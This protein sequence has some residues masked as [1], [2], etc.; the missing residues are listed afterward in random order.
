MTLPKLN[1]NTGVRDPVSLAG[2]KNMVPVIT[3]SPDGTETYTWKKQWPS[4]Y[5]TETVSGRGNLF[6]IKFSFCMGF[7]AWRIVLVWLVIKSILFF[8][9]INFV[10]HK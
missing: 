6:G 10:L 9:C 5:G 8:G 2:P 7:G 4:S 3:I 1:A